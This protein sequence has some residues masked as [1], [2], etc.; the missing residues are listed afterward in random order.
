MFTNTEK[1]QQQPLNS[2]I[3]NTN[4]LL[5]CFGASK[6]VYY[7]EMHIENVAGGDAYRKCGWRGR[8]G[9]IFQ[10]FS[11]ASNISLLSF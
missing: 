9:E 5:T 11:G 1:V 4:I 2:S 6:V 10:M 3:S 8:G 7:T